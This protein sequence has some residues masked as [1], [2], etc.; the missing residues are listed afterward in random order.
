[1]PRELWV[2]V[3]VEMPTDDKLF[4]RPVFERYLWLCLLTLAKK[5]NENGLI[6]H[7]TTQGLANKFN[8][9]SAAKVA[10]A[11]DYF[12]KVRMIELRTDGD[13]FLIHFAARQALSKAQAHAAAQAKYRKHHSDTES[14]SNGVTGD[15]SEGDEE[16]ITSDGEESKREEKETT[17]PPPPQAGGST[18]SLQNHKQKRLTRQDRRHLETQASAEYRANALADQQAKANELDA[19][20]RS[21]PPPEVK[22]MIE[23]FGGGT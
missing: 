6:H 1:M 11:L 20:P 12:Q 5:A 23:K 10:L 19:I 14:D 7:H 13:I 16:D 3:S 15:D 4:E 22:A 18:A 8:L 21:T 9:G 17:T 2:Q